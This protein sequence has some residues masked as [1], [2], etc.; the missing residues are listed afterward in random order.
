LRE[1]QAF[2]YRRQLDSPVKV[3]PPPYGR[4]RGEQSIGQLDLE[5]IRWASL[6]QPKYY[7]C[8]TLLF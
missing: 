6:V 2:G 3:E 8:C 7:R 4:R 1:L 5:G